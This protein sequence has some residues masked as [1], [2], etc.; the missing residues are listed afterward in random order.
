MSPRKLLHF[1]HPVSSSSLGWADRV[2][3]RT[4]EGPPPSFGSHHSFHPLSL[5]EKKIDL[6]AKYL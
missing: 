2:L 4:Q 1:V 3:I 5:V 6:E